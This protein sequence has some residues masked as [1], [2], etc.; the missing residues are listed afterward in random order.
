M[1]VVFLI[2]SMLMVLLSSAY[3]EN[4]DG[5]IVEVEFHLLAWERSDTNLWIRDG[6]GERRLVASLSRPSGPYQYRGNP[7]LSIYRKDLNEEREVILTTVA[8][9]DLSG[10]DDSHLL[11]IL[12][13]NEREHTT[14]DKYRLVVLRDVIDPRRM[15]YLSMYNFSN[16]RIAGLLNDQSFDL[17]PSMHTWIPER[18]GNDN[19]LILRIAQ[20]GDGQ[21]KP[22]YSTIWGARDSTQSVV[23]LVP[24]QEGESVSFRQFRLRLQEPDMVGESN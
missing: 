19:N 4:A 18:A 9:T 20:E 14:A 8:T 5:A 3:T 10:S 16:R 2:T 24:S 11:L 15:G 12:L 1:R 6:S 23:I 7:N 21:W 17:A 13:S 22:I